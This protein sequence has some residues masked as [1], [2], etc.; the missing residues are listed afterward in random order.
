MTDRTYTLQSRV[1]EWMQVCF[2]PEISA[3]KLER[4]DRLLEEVFELL[5]S[6][7]YPTERIQALRDYV[8]SRAKGEPHKEVGGVM[9]TLAAYCLAHGLDMHDA[10]EDEIARITHPDVVRKIRRKQA[11]KPPGSALP[12]AVEYDRTY[13]RAELDAA[14]AAAY[15]KAA[16]KADAPL[17]HR[18]GKPGLWRQRRAAI[19]AE[20][21]ALINDDNLAALEAVRQEE[22]ERLAIMFDRKHGQWAASKG[23][24]YADYTSQWSQA[25]AAI[26]KGDST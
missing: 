2:G 16:E 12:I 8:W 26:R 11:E 15:E 19:A 18:K 3:D 7:D 25:A 21:R 14:V 6:G 9:I 23:R 24:N 10:G 1:A 17:A 20:I 4:G 5:Q 13:T 22:R